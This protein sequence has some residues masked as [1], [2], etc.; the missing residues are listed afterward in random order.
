M[1]I[2]SFLFEKKIGYDLQRLSM[3]W[4]KNKMG[5]NYLNLSKE[6][7]DWLFSYMKVEQEY[8]QIWY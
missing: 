4:F 2:P 7:D 3:F 5:K 8:S 1:I 6:N